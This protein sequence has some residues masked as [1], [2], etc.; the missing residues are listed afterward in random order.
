MNGNNYALIISYLCTTISDNFTDQSVET[1]A[2]NFHAKF[3]SAGVTPKRCDILV[4][5]S[6]YAQVCE[7]CRYV[8]GQLQFIMTHSSID[9]W[10]IVYHHY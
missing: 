4:A 6:L 1:N 5:V 3:L 8:S 10:L 9:V 7:V 2:S